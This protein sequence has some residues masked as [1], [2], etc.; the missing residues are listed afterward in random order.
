MIVTNVYDKN[1]QS[2]IKII[3]QN[4]LY[5]Q[6]SRILGGEKVTLLPN[7]LSLNDELVDHAV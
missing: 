2:F 7:F 6:P 3:R 1:D 5:I 4:R